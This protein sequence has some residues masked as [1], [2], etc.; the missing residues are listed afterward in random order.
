MQ[1]SA[2]NIKRLIPRTVR[3]L[4]RS[5]LDWEERK[6]LLL[7][8]EKFMVST[9]EEPEVR[10]ISL[11]RAGERRYRTV[12]SLQR[13]GI[14]FR[15][16]DA[17]DGLSPVSSSSIA[18]YAGPKKTKRLKATQNFSSQQVL[19]LHEKVRSSGYVTPTL[20]IALHERLRFGCYLSHVSLWQRLVQDELEYLVILEDDVVVTS[21]FEGL[22]LQNL[23]SLPKSWDLLYLN[24]CFKHLGPIFR[25]GLR[26]ARGGLC[27]YGYVISHKGAELL[28]HKGALHSDKPI[29]HMLDEEVLTGNIVAFH[30][31]PPFVFL[32]HN[33]TS[34]LAYV[35]NDIRQ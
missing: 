11:S 19:R 18:K 31:D 21:D 4:R 2:E 13:A 12:A 27:T 14:R 8:E 30:S 9:A 24:G 22:L 25:K 17:V 5:S 16:F 29:D 34:T 1:N 6:S 3:E 28:L 23:N 35:K 32:E 20:R 26:L 33:V 10:V 7:L 15:S